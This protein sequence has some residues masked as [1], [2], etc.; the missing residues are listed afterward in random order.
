MGRWFLWAPSRIFA[1]SLACLAATGCA[2]QHEFSA[3]ADLERRLHRDIDVRTT[4]ASESVA[5]ARTLAGYLRVALERNPGIRAGF[6]RWQASVHRIARARRLPEPTLGFG[7]FVQSVETRL[8]PQRG[9]ISLQQAFPWPTKL[10]AGADAASLQARAMARRLDAQTLSVARAV[11]TAYWN[12]WELRT[13]KAI[14][15]EHLEVIQ[16][17]ASAVRA[18]VSTGAAMLSDLQQVELLVT[19][20][21]DDLQ[22]LEEAERGAVFQLRAAIGTSAMTA[23]HELPTPDAPPDAWFPVESREVLASWVRAHPMIESQ[24]VLAE[25]AVSMGRAEAADRWPSFTLGADWI[26]TSETSMAGVEHSGRDAVIASLGIR[27]PLW[28][29]SY[30]ESVAAAEADARAQYA[31]QQ[32]MIDQAEAELASTLVHLHDAVRRVAFYRGRL[33]PQAQTAYESVLGAYVVGRATVAQVLLSERDLLELR[34]ELERARVAH[35]RWSARLEELV[36]RELVFA[37]IDAE[38]VREDE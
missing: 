25:A 16:G 19:R 7:Y 30:G 9:R 23:A 6:E 28:Q 31:E 21:E 29:G 8:G 24:G 14:R 27:V 5:S 38:T 12:L 22:G 1:W 2:A 18:R 11:K 37:A 36:G 4:T 15:R 17:L 33:V 26:L 35:A 34:T 13:T 3:R 20:G 32:A 10:T